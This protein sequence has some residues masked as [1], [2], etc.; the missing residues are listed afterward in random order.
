LVRYEGLRSS[1]AKVHIRVCQGSILGSLLFLIHVADLPD[2]IGV[3]VRS[4][5]SK[6]NNGKISNTNS[7]TNSYGDDSH[8]TVIG[9]AVD[10]VVAQLNVKAA[11]FAD[12]AKGNGLALNGKKISSSCPE[13][14]GTSTA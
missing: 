6:N 10:E 5:S 1:I 2:A 3:G 12:W 9:D 13:T 14:P 4:S 11:L 7:Q 8:V